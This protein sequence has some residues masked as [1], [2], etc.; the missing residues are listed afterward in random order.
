MVDLV[1]NQFLIIKILKHK[2]GIA[3]LNSGIEPNNT[4]RNGCFIKRKRSLRYVSFIKRT[5][6]KLNKR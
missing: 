4:Q 3:N 1:G 6:K 5:N 2:K